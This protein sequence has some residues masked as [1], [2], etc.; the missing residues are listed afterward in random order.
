MEQNRVSRYRYTHTHTYMV[1]KFFTNLLI[2]FNGEQVTF[3]ANG[4]GT[5]GYPNEKK[6]NMIYK[7]LEMYQ[8]S[9][10]KS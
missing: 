4:V 9:D 5:I 6:T 2:Q 7:T 3:L 1:N 10:H 8:D